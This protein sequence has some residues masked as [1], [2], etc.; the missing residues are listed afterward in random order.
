MSLSVF[1][2]AI[3]CMYTSVIDRDL[4]LSIML[5]KKS[6]TNPSHVIIEN[7]VVKRRKCYFCKPISIIV[8]NKDNIIF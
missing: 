5:L 7:P 1:L 3:V 2:S 6:A 4:I 8:D